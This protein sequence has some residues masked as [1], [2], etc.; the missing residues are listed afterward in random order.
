MTH[1]KL[2][3]A[4]WQSLSDFRRQQQSPRQPETQ[5]NKRKLHLSPLTAHTQHM[6]PINAK[7]HKYDFICESA[8]VYMKREC[9]RGCRTTPAAAAP[10]LMQTLRSPF[11]IWGYLSTSSSS[12]A[13]CIAHNK[14]CIVCTC[15]GECERAGAP[16]DTHASAFFKRPDEMH[17]PT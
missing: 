13:M 17:F 11:I 14:M 5:Y 9:T 4:F 10:P 1:W 15:G 7:A 12:A 16:E 3:L 8:I 2:A 6:Q